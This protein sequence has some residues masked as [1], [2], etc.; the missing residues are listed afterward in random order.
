MLFDLNKVNQMIKS[1]AK[2][3]L[4]TIATEIDACIEIIFIELLPC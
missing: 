2:A 3:E 4:R 1:F